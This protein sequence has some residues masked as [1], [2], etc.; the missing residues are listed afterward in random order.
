MQAGDCR[1]FFWLCTPRGL[2][3]RSEREREKERGSN[4][5]P[6]G[7][8]ETAQTGL[9]PYLEMSLRFCRDYNVLH[10]E[11]MMYGYLLASFVQERCPHMCEL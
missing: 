10:W 5:K 4:H 3:R 7:E 2:G 11:S 6:Q 8:K 9:I 1:T